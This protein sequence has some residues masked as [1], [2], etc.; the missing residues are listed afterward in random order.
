MPIICFLFA[1]FHLTV[2]QN[3]K[4]NSYLELHYIFHIH[5][6]L[7]LLLVC[8]KLYLFPLKRHNEIKNKL[9]KLFKFLISFSSN[10]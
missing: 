8:V 10:I 7:F 1:L 6:P 9:T 3:Q 4:H 5:F 2:Y